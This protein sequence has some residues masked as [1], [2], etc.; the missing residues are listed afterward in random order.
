MLRELST[1]NLLQQWIDAAEQFCDARA[2][3][4]GRFAIL[5]WKTRFEYVRRS[6]EAETF[7]A[8]EFQIAQEMAEHL[9]KAKPRFRRDSLDRTLLRSTKFVEQ[10]GNGVMDLADRAAD[11]GLLSMQAAEQLDLRV[12]KTVGRRKRALNRRRVGKPV[13]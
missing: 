4:Y 8:C 5:T 2:P 6:F 11:E 12:D 1:K 7:V 9:V 3:N 13:P 10:V